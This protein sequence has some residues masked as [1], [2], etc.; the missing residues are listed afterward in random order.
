MLAWAE[1]SEAEYP[2]EED[3]ENAE[4]ELVVVA[5]VR[6]RL[7]NRRPQSGRSYGTGNLVRQTASYDSRLQAIVGHQLANGLRAPLVI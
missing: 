5:S 6:R 2:V 7:N 3:G 4:E 1:L